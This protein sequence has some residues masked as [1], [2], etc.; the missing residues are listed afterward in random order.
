M[1]SVLGLGCS[2]EVR[3]V[4]AHVLLQVLKGVLRSVA[5][6]IQAG[7]VHVPSRNMTVGQECVGRQ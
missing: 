2:G 3:P 5:E 1:L 7:V 6:G 4:D